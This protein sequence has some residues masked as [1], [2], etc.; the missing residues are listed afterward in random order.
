MASLRP[1]KAIV[2]LYP[3]SIAVVYGL[4]AIF[5]VCI[6]F[7]KGGVGN[8]LAVCSFVAAWALIARESRAGTLSIPPL[9]PIAVVFLAVIT[10]RLALPPYGVETVPGSA[11]V[12]SL[13]LV[14]LYGLA[15][16]AY[17]R[18]PFQYILWMIAIAAALCAA[19]AIAMYLPAPPEDFRL[20]FVGRAS[21][22][23]MGAGAVACG[24][25]AAVTLLFYGPNSGRSRI[26]LAL[27]C[28]V[29]L[30]GIYLTRSRGPML[31]LALSLALT[32]LVLRFSSWKVLLAGAIVAWG[33]VTAGVLLDGP[34]KAALCSFTEL[35]CRSSLRHDVWRAS[36]DLIAAHP[37]WGSGYG[38][39]FEGVPHA[40]N[41]YLGLAL[42]YG[43]P[44]LVLF[45]MLLATAFRSVGSL[46]NGCEKFFIVAMLIFANG[47]MGSDLSDPMRF[48]STH[49]LFL[50]LPLFFALMS[51]SAERFAQKPMAT[52]PA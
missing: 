14:G 51:V 34:I 48:F 41:G 13:L 40:H 28:V 11:V 19:I 42:H 33:L 8:A 22:P 24:F 30:V 10:A 37:L 20:N 5:L 27:M 7:F 23:I 16:Y 52:A 38:F 21:H 4:F 43:L 3:G 47:F 12:R 29:M 35:A 49:Y 2:A 18:L 6:F 44:V 50:W 39:R 9:A 26:V 46:A 45:L 17:V 32:P 36:L 1:S 25:I 15:W 31:S